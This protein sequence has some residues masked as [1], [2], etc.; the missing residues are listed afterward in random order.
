MAVPIKRTNGGCLKNIVA[1]DGG[2][3]ETFIKEDFPSSS[4]TF[5]NF[6][7][8]LFKLNDLNALDLSEFIDPLDLAKL[9]QFQRHSLVL[10][11]KNISLKNG[12]TL[13]MSVR[14]TLR[15]FFEERDGGGERLIESVRWLVFQEWQSEDISWVL[16]RCPYQNCLGKDITF[17]RA[18]GNEVPCDFCG[19][20]VWLTETFRLHEAID[21]EQGAGGTLGYLMVL[22]EQM[23]LAQWIRFV[24]VLR[25]RC[26]MKYCSLRT[27]HWLSLDRLQ[28]FTS[29]CGR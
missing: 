2:F 8:L 6:G 16:A 12:N 3:T 4:L 28:T 27:A 29:Q 15:D 9:K 13:T 26:W 18:K 14:L 24:C 10:P 19:R 22:L 21:D 20:P 1:L 11:T 25:P 5:Y 7:P 17:T 23:I